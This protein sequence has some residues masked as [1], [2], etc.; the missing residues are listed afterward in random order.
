M[1]AAQLPVLQ[2]VVPLLTAPL[3]VIFRSDSWS[4]L[5]ATVVGWC[6]FAMAVMLAGHVWT[7]GAVSY[8]LGGWAAPWG[9]EYR[10]DALG[11]FVALIVSGI[12]ALVLTFARRSVAAEVPP[13][14]VYLFYAAFL[15]CLCGLLGIVATGDAFN[16]FVFIEISSLSSYALISMGR[17]RQ[18]LF[19]AYQYLIMGTI[20][21][22]FILI[23]VGL[24][25]AM[26]GTLNMADLAQRLPAVETTRTVKAAFAFLT[27]GISLK[28]ALLP[29][30]LWLPNAYTYAPSVISAFLAATTTK[31][32]V[33]VL[34]R[35]LFT[36]FGVHFSVRAM[37]VEWVLMPL[38]ILAIFVGSGAAIFQTNLKRMLAY[39]SVAQIGYMIL[40]ISLVTVTG[41]AAGI[42]HLFNHAL[43]KCALFLALACVV[44]RTGTVELGAMAG[45]GRRMPWTMGAFV[46]GGLSLIGVPLTAGFVSKWYLVLAALER[47]WWPVAVL[48]LL[49][50]L[51]AVIY[52]WRVVEVAYFKPLPPGVEAGT[53]QEAPL[54]MLGV[55][56]LLIAANVYFGVHAPLTAALARRAAQGLLGGGP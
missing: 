55:T 53:G 52:I 40:G 18:A 50:S 8:A 19:A 54:V 15:L 10:V 51:L 39:S 21:A 30:H 25:Y 38:A 48:I 23:G 1:I 29:L 32:F 37:H 13:G 26:T 20:G 2:V 34:L 44:Y 4:W 12:A 5:L 47:G 17:R 35:F 16:L 33:Y 27:V 22:T 45:M 42:I 24:L 31:V 11:S 14:R 28:L 9:I 56:W 7:S 43:M 6:V 41:V 36:V 46:A 49:G 3:C